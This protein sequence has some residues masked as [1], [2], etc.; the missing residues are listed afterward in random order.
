MIHHLGY[1]TKQVNMS[2]VCVVGQDIHIDADDG[3]SG[4]PVINPAGLLVGLFIGTQTMCLRFIMT[5]MNEK[6]DRFS[7]LLKDMSKEE[8]IKKRKCTLE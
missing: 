8:P 6:S 7:C 5:D 4:S 1:G 2:G 3:S